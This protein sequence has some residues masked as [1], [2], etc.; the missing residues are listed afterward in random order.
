MACELDASDVIP[1]PLAPKS[2][3]WFSGL[4]SLYV[5]QSIS[6]ATYRD[7][8]PSRGESIRFD[9]YG[10]PMSSRVSTVDS[11]PYEWQTLDSTR[12]TD[13]PQSSQ[14][15]KLGEGHEVQDDTLIV[16][17]L[18]TTG[19]NETFAKGRIARP[20]L[21]LDTAQISRLDRSPSKIIARS[22]RIVEVD[23]D[24]DCAQTSASSTG[25]AAKLFDSSA[26]PS[27]CSDS[28]LAK[29]SFYQKPIFDSSGDL[30]GLQE[31]APPSPPADKSHIRD[32]SLQ[33]LS[34]GLGK[35]QRTDIESPSRFPGTQHL[36][37][38]IIGRMLLLHHHSTS[39]PGPKR[40]KGFDVFG[41]SGYYAFKTGTEVLRNIYKGT[42]PRTADAACA[43]IQVTLQFISYIPGHDSDHL[44]DQMRHDIR[45]WSLLIED[46][47]SRDPFL[48][49][50]NT[51]LVKWRSSQKVEPPTRTKPSTS[52]TAQ[53]PSAFYQ[54]PFEFFRVP[55][56]GPANGSTD[57]CNFDRFLKDSVIMHICS[58]FLDGKDPDL[59]T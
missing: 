57:Q 55:Q 40:E 25:Y 35:T 41:P 23:D 47:T 7:G 38:E 39:G 37:Q 5:P 50:M 48:E 16:S 43:L 36:L 14:V 32:S 4:E 17:T 1:R 54:R 18:S 28:S 6:P 27:W 20:D 30:S 21:S 15:T 8:S 46:K 44:W 56:T 24:A 59:R 31:V 51:L 19:S 11:G 12:D 22:V 3:L 9:A 53:A 52:Q 33:G 2:P 26:A 42:L 49:A 29:P 58:R 34:R 13:G 10:T 45:R